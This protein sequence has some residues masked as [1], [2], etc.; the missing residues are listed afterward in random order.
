MR[1]RQLQ[2]NQLNEALSP[3]QGVDCKINSDISFFCGYLLILSDDL[4]RGG[5]CNAFVLL[6]VLLRILIHLFSLYHNYHAGHVYQARRVIRSN[7]HAFCSNND[8][9]I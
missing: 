8:L 5:K 3:D 1:W 4:L 2:S 9:E 6:V 7:D